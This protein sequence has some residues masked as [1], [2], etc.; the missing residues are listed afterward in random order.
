MKNIRLLI[1]VILLGS[2]TSILLIG[3]DMLTADRILQNQDAEVKSIVLTAY[4]ISF[5][6]TTIHDI[7]DEKVEQYEI[8][9]MNET[10]TFYQDKET[11]KISFPFIGDGVWDKISGM[12]TLESDFVTISDISIISQRETPGLGGIVA[13]RDY[14]DT[15]VGKTFLNEVILIIKADNTPNATNEVDAISGATRTSQQFNIILNDAY[16]SYKAAW[17]SQLEG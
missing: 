11:M 5:N 1:F 3:M 6:Y 9:Y 16:A 15:F 13:E 4:D 10:Y 17:D 14:L 2:I 12:I 7:F 8:T